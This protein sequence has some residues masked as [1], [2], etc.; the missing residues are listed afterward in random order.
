MTTTAMTA[1]RARDGCEMTIK[2]LEQ[3]SDDDGKAER[4]LGERE[5]FSYRDIR[6]YCGVSRWTVLR[7]IQSGELP[8]SKVG[9]KVLVRRSDIDT[10]LESRSPERKARRG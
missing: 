2:E 6:T 10:W 1:H 5:W 9:R 4:I 3:R 8:A 7:L